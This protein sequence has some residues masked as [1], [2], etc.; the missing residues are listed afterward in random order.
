MLM[1]DAES[2]KIGSEVKVAWGSQQNQWKI[3]HQQSLLNESQAHLGPL[4]PSPA[5]AAQARTFAKLQVSTEIKQGPLGCNCPRHWRDTR[6]QQ[7]ASSSQTF[8]NRHSCRGHG[9]GCA[10][11]KHVP[12][13]PGPGTQLEA[14]PSSQETSLSQSFSPQA[15]KASGDGSQNDKTSKLQTERINGCETQE[16]YMQGNKPANGN[17]A[18]IKAVNKYLKHNHIFIRL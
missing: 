1:N 7:E 12:L 14:Q 18:E 4:E 3:C 10:A 15:W 5:A 17:T 9:Q 11:P 8:R 13:Y 6:D 16:A 2:N